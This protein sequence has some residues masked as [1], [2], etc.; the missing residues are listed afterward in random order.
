MSAIFGILRFD[1]A[2]VARRDLERMA[3]AARRRGP[4]ASAV[5]AIG[6]VGLGHCLLRVNR[7]DLHEAQP[8]FDDDAGLALIA[9]CRID[10]REPLAEEFGWSASSLGDRPDSAF[11]LQAYK[12]WGA[13]APAH[14]LGDFAFAVWD[15]GARTLFLARD[16]MGQR[17]V[18]Y[19]RGDAL[20]A[21]ATDLAALWSLPEAPRALREQA[22][23]S[24]LF[25][26]AEARRGTTFY[27]GIEALPGGTSLTVHR[28]GR[29]ELRSYWTPRADPRHAGHDEAYYIET[30]RALLLDAVSSRVARLLKP[31]ALCLSGGIDSG[32]IAAMAGPALKNA[33]MPLI[34]LSSVA[35]EAGCA[36]DARDAVEACARSMPHLDVHY[37]VRDQ[38]TLLDDLE[39]N[40]AELGIPVTTD[41][42]FRGL[43]ATARAAGARLLMDGHGGDYTLNFRGPLDWSG[44]LFGGKFGRLWHE[45]RASARASGKWRWGALI[46]HVAP[47]WL[48]ASLL[49]GLATL[50]RGFAPSWARGTIDPG[51][52][53]HLIRGGF[54]DPRNVR[55]SHRLRGANRAWMMRVIEIQR[56]ATTVAPSV[57]AGTM[58]LEFTRPFHDR[59]IVEFALAIPEELYFRNGRYRYL[60]RRALADVLPREALQGGPNAAFEPD[61]ATMRQQAGAHAIAEMHRMEQEPALAARIDFAKARRMLELADRQ[62]DAPPAATGAALQA[63]AIGRF[64]EWNEQRNTRRDANGPALQ[65]P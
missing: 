8:L 26:D 15:G 62:P 58:G 34:G 18:H 60:A 24:M 31:P 9:D 38:E 27:Q 22:L 14:L 21:F 28:D 50:R 57:I 32:A 17:Y 13:E 65:E 25:G 11:I 63:V 40:F 61:Y 35:R 48:P 52:A 12:R 1:D 41:Y 46:G 39:R 51:Y 33:Q 37:Y 5:E 30:Y 16:P 23:G 3:A 4:D 45:S 10:N 43:A 55:G 36:K 42:V 59:R 29:A 20:F 53:R 2:E 56:R 64:L 54:V 19:H 7:E 44:W 6:P 49:D 47:R